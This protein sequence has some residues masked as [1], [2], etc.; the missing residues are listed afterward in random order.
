M[1]RNRNQPPPSA[2]L[3]APQPELG[4][5]LQLPDVI[6]ELAPEPAPTPESAPEPA[7]E[8]TPAPELKPEPEPEPIRDFRAPTCATRHIPNCECTGAARGRP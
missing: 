3:S 4:D 1:S 2:P 6:T 8:P 5:S 7:P